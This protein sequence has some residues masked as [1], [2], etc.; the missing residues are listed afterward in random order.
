MSAGPID[1]RLL[2]YASASRW[3][4]VAG[5]AVGFLQTASIV[6]SAWFATALIV[7]LIDGRSVAEL[8]PEL[9]AFVGVILAR[10]VLIW[11]LDVLAVRGA[12]RV[13]SQL[14]VRV[15]GALTKLGPAWLAERNSARITTVV[16]QGLDALDGYFAKY[17]PQLILTAIA[18]PLLLL[19]LLTQD[20]ATG[21][22]IIIT[23]PLIPLFMVLIGW[24][25]QAVQKQQWAALTKLASSFLDVVDGLS[26]L[27]IF[28]RQ[29][30]QVERI[31]AVTEDYRARTIAVLRVSF[32]SGFVLELAGSL[33][34]AIVAVS[35]GLRLVDGTL[36]LTV[37]LFVLLL[38]PEAYLPLRQVG[39]QFH[40]AA[41]GVAA[42]D[43]VFEIL[44]AAGG[45]G[46][47]A[48][49]DAPMPV[50]AGGAL[51]VAGLGVAYGDRTVIDDLSVGFEPGVLTAIAGPSGAGKSSLIAAVLGF[52]PSTGLVTY[53]GRVLEPGAARALVAWAGQRP[54]LMAGT[55]AENVALGAAEPDERTLRTAMRLAA[56]ELIDPRQVLG[57]NGAGLSGGQAQRVALARAFYRAL[58]RSCPV[59]ILDEP[60]SALDAAT[61][62]ELVNGLREFVE[63]GVAVVVVSHRTA[64]LDA[65]DS[66]IELRPRVAVAS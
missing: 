15:V 31:D 59:L 51:A 30:R 23:L 7:G 29:H 12:A 13:K 58:D 36:G 61:E 56:A 50:S 34:V 11:A 17:L 42:A 60:S 46:P 52:V 35:I 21:V 25:T 54:G 33:S 47:A 38:T 64:L 27:T 44:D 63:R 20:V 3:F 5:A 22:V 37:G 62:G 39:A 48:S 45:A 16:S 14:R 18:T 4:L 53:G 8:M 55:V 32:I 57:V 24:A 10:A 1:P 41:D 9:W 66:V 28:G 65:A 6:A 2:R 40:A 43:E 49:V 19:V 26:T